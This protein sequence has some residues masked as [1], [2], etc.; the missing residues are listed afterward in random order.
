MVYLRL[1]TGNA[2]W[3]SVPRLAQSAR[4]TFRSLDDRIRELCSTVV[5]TSDS[6]EFAVATEEL[7]HVLRE[8]MQHIR[9]MIAPF[10]GPSERRPLARVTTRQP[11]VHCSIC[12]QGLRLES[13]MANEEGQPVHEECYVASLSQNPVMFY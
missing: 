12:A 2:V 5:E 6:K 11:P 8:Q 9:K 13:A 7:R 4:V 1:P 3:K 10:P